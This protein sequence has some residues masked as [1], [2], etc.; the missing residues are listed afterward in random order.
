MII[1]THRYIHA[2]ANKSMVT[3][4]S[5]VANVFLAIGWHEINAKKKRPRKADL[6]CPGVRLLIHK[7]LY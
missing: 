2:E 4:E 3:R 1:Y 7:R 5:S 6:K